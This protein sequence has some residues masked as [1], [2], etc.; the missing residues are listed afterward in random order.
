MGD[1]AILM[2]RLAEGN[3][4]HDAP[5]PER[6]KPGRRPGTI[7]VNGVGAAPSL[8]P[9][10]QTGTTEP[11]GWLS[12]GGGAQAGPTTWKIT[13]PSGSNT[14]APHTAWLIP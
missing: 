7:E 1:P 3:R 10:G 8:P 13:W 2:G 6:Y 5:P 14:F 4:A 12:S 11:S 9:T